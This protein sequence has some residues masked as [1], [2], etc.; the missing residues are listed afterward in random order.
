MALADRVGYD[1]NVYWEKAPDYRTSR[2]LDW[3]NDACEAKLGKEERQ[4]DKVEY[5]AL[6]SPTSIAFTFHDAERSAA[7]K[8]LF[9]QASLT[10]QRLGKRSPTGK[11]P[12]SLLLTRGLKVAAEEKPDVLGAEEE[13]NGTGTEK[14]RQIPPYLLLGKKRWPGRRAAVRK[15]ERADIHTVELVAERFQCTL[16]VGAV[17]VDVRFATDFEAKALFDCLEEKSE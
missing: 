8:R 13:P 3:L 16:H 11:Y 1:V 2:T 10:R 9:A 5:A 12:I 14:Y 7:W 4:Q 15:Y 17:D 6:M